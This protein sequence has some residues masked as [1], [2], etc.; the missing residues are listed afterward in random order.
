MK[1]RS[2]PLFLLCAG[3][4]AAAL[5]AGAAP[6][7]AQ[8]AGRFTLTTEA[9]RDEVLY[10]RG[11]WKFHP[12]D[13]PAWADPAYDDSSWMVVEAQSQRPGSEASAILPPSRG[14]PEV[15]WFRLRL[16]V[17]PAARGERFGILV[18]DWAPGAAALY[19]DG[20]LVFDGWPDG[21][22][23][24]RSLR[25]STPHVVDLGG[26]EHVIAVRYSL[27]AAEEVTRRSPAP[28]PGMAVILTSGAMAQHGFVPL[29]A[30]QTA[31]LSIL[32]GLLL[33]F[34]VLHLLLFVFFA[35]PAAN[36]FFALF[37]LSFAA[38]N[39][40]WLWGLV[41]PSIEWTSWANWVNNLV[42]AP[43]AIMGLGAFTYS[44]FYRRP[45]WHAWAYGALVLL[46]PVLLL[47]TSPEVFNQAFSWI[48]LLLI[49]TI[50]AV[51]G[52]AFRQRKEGSA[53][54]GLGLLIALGSYAATHVLPALGL[55]PIPSVAI[56]FAGLYGFVPLL[57][58]MSVHLARSHA[59][60]SR[61][62]ERLAG[63]LEE[64]NRTLEQR[65]EQRTA[66]LTASERKYRTLI[67]HANDAILLIGTEKLRVRDA[68][69]AAE[70]LLGYAR[71]QLA[72]M[73][74]PALCPPGEF[75]HYREL[76]RAHIENG[77]PISE[78]LYLLHAGGGRI[79]V[80]I[81]ASVV[82]VGGERLIQGIVHDLTERKRAEAALEEAK[83]LAEQ[84]NQTKSRFLA[85]MSHEL[86][87][88]LNA[89]IGYSEMLQ[90]D[91]EEAGQE[92][93][94][95]D[96]EK[97][98]GAGRHLLELINGILDLSKVEAGRME[99]FLER[100]GTGPFVR[101]RGNALRVEIESAPAHLHTD[102]T[103]LKQILLNLLGNAAKF[104]ENGVVTLR[105]ERH[106]AEDGER[107]RFRVIDTGIG[108]TPEQVER[109]FQPFT[110]A[111]ASTTR[112]YGGTGLGLTITRGF[113]ELM[114]GTVEVRSEPGAGTE[115]MVEL[116]AEVREP[117]GPAVRFDG[118]LDGEAGADPGAVPDA[119][120]AGEPEP[121]R[122]LVI[123]DDA[124]AREVI[125]RAL[126]REGFRV[127]L[128]ASGDEGLRLAKERRPDVVTLDVLM[129]G[130][131]GWTVLESL[132]ADPELAEVPVIMVSFVEEK[133][134][135]YS[136]G[137]A[138][139]LTKPVERD[140][141]LAALRRHLDGSAGGPL[142]VV[143]DDAATREMLR[144]TLE[145]EGWAV[146]EAENGR[147]GL[148]R[149][150]ECAPRAV[151]L[152]LMMPEMDG[153]EF[154]DAL[155][156]DP[157]H[158]A[159]PVIV[160][161]AKELTNQERDR[162]SGSVQRILRKGEHSREQLADEVRRLLERRGHRLTV[163]N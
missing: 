5:L 72:E 17:D 124:D 69:A 160:V 7:D 88:P 105:V 158:A 146:A 80:E 152:D 141:L 113:V 125:G 3:L 40:L 111:D 154:L 142:L 59:R 61:G 101:Q 65:V 82:E 95:P 92:A 126:A 159:L 75:E 41:A 34:A 150:A 21:V 36:L 135:A 50:V 131:D 30:G 153:F 13:D 133:K 71:E 148:E 83:R 8:S 87:T 132:K 108:M 129:P 77:A 18:W 110:Q 11:G 55:F 68:N 19:L 151:V 63:E 27:A 23:R 143:E 93:L 94:V 140:R 115:F 112:R 43:L 96:L 106:G 29:V 44:L 42:A 116:P 114:G 149:V 156:R 127:H 70:R 89:I 78:E 119:A 99:L 54:F 52:A 14:G 74:L 67:E 51:V 15:G 155:R 39:G 46:L 103:K 2:A 134:L 49:G 64:A 84:A 123:D 117:A 6:L 31:A 58:A 1:R 28:W 24:T 98:Q 130:T 35:R 4:L 139:Y 136:L 25:M 102:A 147:A 90:E 47:L 10:L 26:P 37:A 22:T 107:V 12:G 138:D 53:L 97:I 16:V 48:A 85:N 66:E 161:T 162:L 137:A 118:I 91:A 73:T 122:V 163:A 20:R 157:R 76:F 145:R 109:L 144:R 9:V 100:L 38:V 104:T 86:R 79:P 60:A 121:A 56:Q 33:A 45:P 32:I 57:L 120:A 62:F 128:A 81:S